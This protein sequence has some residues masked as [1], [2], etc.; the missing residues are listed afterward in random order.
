MLTSYFLGFQSLNSNRMRET[1]ATK[2]L[3]IGISA[4]ILMINF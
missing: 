1:A 3:E 4:G 2:T